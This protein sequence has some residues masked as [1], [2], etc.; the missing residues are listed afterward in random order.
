MNIFLPNLPA[1]DFCDPSQEMLLHSFGT[2]SSLKGY[3]RFRAMALNF[4]FCELKI[5]EPSGLT[6]II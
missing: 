3:S 6:I 1:D 5:Y 4:F 2:K